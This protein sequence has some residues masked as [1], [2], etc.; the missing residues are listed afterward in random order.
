LQQ[1]DATKHKNWYHNTENALLTPDPVQLPARPYQ[2][3]PDKT[4]VARPVRLWPARPGVGTAALP[5]PDPANFH[6]ETTAIAT[7]DRPDSA[8][9]DTKPKG[10]I[11]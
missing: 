4:V 6:C 10:F 9:K 8:A 2:G 11:P 3:L 7:L 5:Y 1:P